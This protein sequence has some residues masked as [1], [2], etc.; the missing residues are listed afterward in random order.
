VIRQ[1]LFIWNESK[2]SN[3]LHS[4]NYFLVGKAEVDGTLD[5][6]GISLDDGTLDVD[7]TLEVDGI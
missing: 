1:H 2:G 7:G 5:I 3:A 6:D 4:W